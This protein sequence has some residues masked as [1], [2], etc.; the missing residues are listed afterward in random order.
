MRARGGRRP[1][2]CLLPPGAQRMARVSALRVP[3]VTPSR[4]LACRDKAGEDALGLFWHRKPMAH[5]AIPQWQN[6]VV[7]IGA[8]RSGG[9]EPT[10]K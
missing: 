5:G 9:A 8:L 10:L 4:K 1:R 7:A 2:P 3:C 6:G